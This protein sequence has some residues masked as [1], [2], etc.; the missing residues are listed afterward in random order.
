MIT[1]YHASRLLIVADVYLFIQGIQIIR[2]P[3]FLRVAKLYKGVLRD[4]LSSSQIPA[5]G[6]ISGLNAQA[7]DWSYTSVP[8]SWLAFVSAVAGV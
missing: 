3:P 5:T 7:E 2:F 1:T 8:S 4:E 6:R